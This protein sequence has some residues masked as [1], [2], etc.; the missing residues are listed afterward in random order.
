[1]MLGEKTKALDRLEHVAEYGRGDPRL[2]EVLSKT[3]SMI[4]M[5]KSKP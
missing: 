1:M 2:T 5:L 4:E 3:A